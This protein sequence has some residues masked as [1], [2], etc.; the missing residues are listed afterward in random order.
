[1]RLLRKIRIIVERAVKNL[2]GL[3][4]LI[5]LVRLVLKFLGA[6]PKAFVVDLI[7]KYTDILLAP[8]EFIFQDIYFQNR[9]IE[10]AVISAMIGY[11]IL[12]FVV[13]KLL[14]LFSRD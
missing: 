14:H 3:A 8:F 9:I 4:S 7:Y 1:M 10:T 2:L 11:S 6:S 5:L 12:V 13:F